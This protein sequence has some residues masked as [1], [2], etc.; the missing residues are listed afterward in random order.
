MSQGTKKA[1]YGTWE[2]PVTAE[3]ITKNANSI[4]ALLVDGV[5][6]TVYNLERRPSEGGRSVL[7]ETRSGK[8]VL[9][10]KSDGSRWNV[11]TGVQEYGGSPALVHNNIVYFSHYDDGRIYSKELGTE[12]SKVIGVTPAS[13]PYRFANL[14]LHPSDSHLLFAVLEDHTDDTPAGVVTSLCVIDTSNQSGDDKVSVIVKGAD[15]YALPSFSPSVEGRPSKLT[16]MEWYHPDMPWIGGEVYVGDV[17]IEGGAVKVVNRVKVSGER[18]KISAC[19]PSWLNESALLFTNDESGFVNPWISNL[20]SARPVLPTPLPEDFGYPFWSLDEFP[21][22][23][24]SAGG[25]KGAVWK[26]IK[27][28]RDVLYYIPVGEGKEPAKAHLIPS[29]YVSLGPSILALPGGKEVVFIGQKADEEKTIVQVSVEGLIEGNA[30]FVGIAVK[31]EKE[32]KKTELTKDLVSAPKPITLKLADGH[33]LHVVYY[34]PYNPAY[35]GPNDPSEKP[36]VVVNIHGGPTA[37]VSQ[38]LDWKKQYWTTR[39]WAWLDV[40]YRGSSGYG[41]AYIEQLNRNWGVVDV[42]DCINSVRL[43]SGGEHDLVDPKRA[44]IRGGSAGGFTV[45]AVI[46]LPG[47]YGASVFNGVGVSR[48]LSYRE[49]NRQED[50]CCCPSQLR[51][52]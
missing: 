26:G 19:Y 43:L 37:H 41:R 23:L 28:G 3:A 14:V 45:L 30:E 8:D 18:T 9:G 36:P 2:S 38:G 33:P 1:P 46:S 42:Q 5:T 51:H 50:I 17:V 12:G 24:V 47:T 15:F 16:W 44:V 27:E 11:R 20:S 29:P 34:A 39:G 7:V 31:K 22:T 35:A 21:Y 40:N 10:P 4:E 25:K 48:A 13:K 6:G 49:R 52:F 32:E